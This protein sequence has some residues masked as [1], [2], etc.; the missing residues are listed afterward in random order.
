MDVVTVETPQ[1]GDRSY[2][3]HDGGV[4]VVIDPQRDLDRMT[5][6][7]ARAGVRVSHVAETHVHNDYVSGGRALAEGT[8]A[9]YVVAAADEVTFQRQAVS[10]G[11]TFLAGPLR[12]SVLATPGHTAGHVSYLVSAPSGPPVLFSGGNL[13]YGSVGRTDL[14]DPALTEELTRRQYRSAQRLAATL[15]D[16]TVIYPTHG[17][18][19]FCSSGPTTEVATSTLGEQKASN[20]ALTTSS[21]DRFV[22]EMLAGLGAYPTYYAHIAPINRRG[23]DATDLS[24]PKPLDP[25]ALYRVIEA[26]E[27]V[28][29]LRGRA[30]YAAAHLGGTVSFELSRD[31]STYVGWVLPWGEP[32]TLLGE[33]SEHVAEAQRDL[34]RIGIDRLAGA[35]VGLIEQFADGRLRCYPRAR[36]GDLRAALSARDA[37]H[38]T[39]LVIVDVRRA[40]EYERGH[41]PGA[42][43]VPVHDL[44]SRLDRLGDI[45]EGTLWVHCASGYR[46][47]IAASILDQAG[48]DV[49]HVDDD[50]S[51]VPEQGLSVTAGR[52]P[53]GETGG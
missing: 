25:A 30:A 35:A 23:A 20:P 47:G 36:W 52:R 46:A 19:S 9:A 4:G 31:F 15:P 28:V 38:A 13:M 22:A 40:D 7:V 39:D 10:D 44:V 42:V 11:A 5:A 18:G 32:L 48:R 33:S 1:L 26:G 12:V 45:P 49:V 50:W 34:S 3:V 21:E 17:F 43:S 53:P 14:A 2:L 51:R 16:D 8:G 29:D 41:L 6:A 37:G 27:W 24:P